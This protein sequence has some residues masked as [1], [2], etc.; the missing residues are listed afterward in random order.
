MSQKKII[1]VLP[2]EKFLLN[3]KNR[4]RPDRA[5]ERAQRSSVAEVGF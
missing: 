5:D 3:Y 4:I 1:F 2:F